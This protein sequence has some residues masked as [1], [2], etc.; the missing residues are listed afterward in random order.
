MLKYSLIALGAIVA[1]LL[2]V[3]VLPQGQRVIP[4]ST[5]NLERVQLTLYPQADPEAVWAFAAP[6]VEYEPE[7]RETTLLNIEDGS[8]SEAGKEDFTLSSDRAV[9]DSEDNLRGDAIAVHLT[10]EDWDLNMQAA[11]GNQVL[12][13]QA[14][15]V[16]EIPDL[17]LKTADDDEESQYQRAR[18]SF[19]LTEFTSGGEGAVGYSRFKIGESDG[20]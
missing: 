1:V 2:T 19:D 9:I 20:E 4:E 12:I 16:F 11:E 17:L 3:S 13:S 5:I 6:Q 15:G 8:R 14:D 18:I 10:E 7:L